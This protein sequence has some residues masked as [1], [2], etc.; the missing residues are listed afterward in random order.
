MCKI[1]N[2]KLII[3]VAISPYILGRTLNVSTSITEIWRHKRVN[4]T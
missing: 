3:P 2:L 1:L 4:K